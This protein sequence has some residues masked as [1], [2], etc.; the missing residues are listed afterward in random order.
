[1][2]NIN[3]EEKKDDISNEKIQQIQKNCKEC[4]R[5]HILTTLN[6]IDFIQKMILDNTEYLKTHMVYIIIYDENL[7]EYYLLN[8]NYGLIGDNHEYLESGNK[9]VKRV[10]LFNHLTSPFMV[11]NSGRTNMVENYLKFLHKTINHLESKNYINKFKN[12]TCNFLF[13]AMKESIS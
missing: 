12:S 3:L 8:S 7:L 4:I 13:N 1:M 11:N 5:N 6:P 9:M 10:Y 2:S